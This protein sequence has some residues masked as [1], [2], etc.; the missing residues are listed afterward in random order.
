MNFFINLF[1]HQMQQQK[2]DLISSIH[3]T[4]DKNF[5]WRFR[6]LTYFASFHFIIQVNNSQI[7]G[8]ILGCLSAKDSFGIFFFSKNGLHNDLL[9]F[10]DYWF[11]FLNSCDKE[12]DEPKTWKFEKKCLESEP[13]LDFSTATF[14]RILCKKWKCWLHK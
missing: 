10:L 13:A 11:T 6:L 14:W 3:Y 12:I 1:V 7:V 8:A 4:L 5:I 9:P 2:T